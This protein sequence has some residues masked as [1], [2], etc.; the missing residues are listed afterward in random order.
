[1]NKKR[2]PVLIYDTSA[3][4]GGM[5]PQVIH[6]PQW[7][8]PENLE[9]V[10][11]KNTRDI[12]D[13]AIRTGRMKLRAPSKEFI[14]K[15]IEISRKTGD[16]PKLSDIDIKVLALALEFYH[17]NWNPIIMTD[18]YTIQNVASH[19]KIEYKAVTEAGIRTQ[20]RWKVFCPGCNTDYPTNTKLKKCEI[21]GTKLKRKSY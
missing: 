9:E 15:I 5:D 11:N 3:F 13:M 19:L 16:Y 14:D 17:E 6:I 1:M 12:L 18:D 2:D 20:L 7:T 10:R 4:I 21:C 8:T